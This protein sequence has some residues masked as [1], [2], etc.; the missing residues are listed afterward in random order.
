MTNDEQL[1][2]L[3]YRNTFTVREEGRYVLGHLLTRLN[4][5]DKCK[6]PEDMALRNVAIELLEDL[7]VL[8]VE[9]AR[10]QYAEKSVGSFV[11][12]IVK[13]DVTPLVNAQE[14]EIKEEQEELI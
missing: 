3:A 1:H 12:A 6:T 13:L 14:K 2:L 9:K 8:F 7:G 11:D 4:F 5:F 10:P